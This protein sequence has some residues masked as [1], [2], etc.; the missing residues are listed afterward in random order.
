MIM[1][2][3]IRYE[4]S[5]SLIKDK[6]EIDEISTEISEAGKEFSIDPLLITYWSFKESRW[7]KKSKGK[8]GEIGVCQAHGSAKNTCVKFGLDM[9]KRSDQFRCMA[10]LFNMNYRKTG[11]I[12]KGLRVYA[13]GSKYK[14]IKLVKKRLKKLDALTKEVKQWQLKKEE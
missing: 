1:I 14:A 9:S 6:N 13:S 10:L 2:L 8:L 5:N 4:P 7:D 11:S 3:L 12:E